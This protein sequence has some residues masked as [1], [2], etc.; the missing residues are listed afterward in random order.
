MLEQEAARKY[1]RA[2]FELAERD[3]KLDR[4]SDQLKSVVST[5]DSHT[6]LRQFMFHPQ[7]KAEIKKDTL[8]K[9]F[10]QDVDKMLLNLLML[11][12]DRRRIS[13]INLVWDEFRRL[14]NA[15]RNL[16]EAE[17]TT[18][19]T[20]SEAAQAALRDKLSLVTGKKIVLHTKVNPAIV[21]GVVVRIGDKLIDG[22]VVRQLG[23]LRRVL[24]STK[25]TRLG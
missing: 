10:G 20:L 18:A 24:T 14:V 2:L 8:Q 1:G 15:A 5:L 19:I 13:A 22:S 17:V 9:V 4:F 21:G 16:E 3:G 7:V 23:D 6:E 25:L 11:L 12:V